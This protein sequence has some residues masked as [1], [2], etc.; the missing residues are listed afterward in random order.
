MDIKQKFTYTPQLFTK[1]LYDIER[2]L[3]YEIE[4]KIDANNFN[5]FTHINVL[6]RLASI[7]EKIKNSDCFI[8]YG[9]YFDIGHQQHQTIQSIM[10]S[11]YT[12][13]KFKNYE[14]QVIA[15]AFSKF[16]SENQQYY[17]QDDYNIF[18][19]ENCIEDTFERILSLTECPRKIDLYYGFRDLV[20]IDLYLEGIQK[21]DNP[22]NP[23]EQIAN[24]VSRNYVIDIIFKIFLNK[25]ERDVDI[26]FM[27]KEIYK[28]TRHYTS[29]DIDRHLTTDIP[30]FPYSEKT[31]ELKG[32]YWQQTEDEE[33]ELLFVCTD[34]YFN[35]RTVKDTEY[36]KLHLITAF[37]PANETAQVF[38]I[39]TSMCERGMKLLEIMNYNDIELSFSNA[40]DIDDTMIK[41]AV[42]DHQTFSNYKE[43]IDYFTFHKGGWLTEE[44]NV[45]TNF[46]PSLEGLNPR[47]WK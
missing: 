19:V 16:Y 11:H 44:Y 6:N 26:T 29:D 2:G 35:V 4:D 3:I 36:R 40:F 24:T 25:K 5:I 15:K 46:R 1:T 22:I 21:L 8:L 41:E 14:E 43:L 27:L 9:D 42:K 37:Y 47:P 18:F 10:L 45:R 7:S 30:E 31:D 28:L 20:P 17:H 32:V 33:F 23:I 34:G 39:E 38:G 12:K 13:G